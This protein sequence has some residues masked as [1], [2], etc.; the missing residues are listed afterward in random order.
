MAHKGAISPPAKGE[1]EGIQQDGL[2][3][4]RLAGEDGEASFMD[5]IELLDQNDVPIEREESMGASRDRVS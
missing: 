3:R 2:A 4:A 1:G 5:E